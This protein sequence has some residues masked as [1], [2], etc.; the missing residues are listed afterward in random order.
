MRNKYKHWIQADMKDDVKSWTQFNKAPIY[1]Q[2]KQD[3][4]LRTSE[5][6]EANIGQQP[7][8]KYN[9]LKLLSKLQQGLYGYSLVPFQHCVSLSLSPAKMATGAK[10]SLMWYLKGNLL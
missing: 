6:V 2:Q 7:Y 4:F 5:G 9:C 3:F 8:M 1:E 10:L